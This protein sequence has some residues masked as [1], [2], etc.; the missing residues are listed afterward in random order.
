YNVTLLSE[1]LGE[2]R[3]KVS[4]ALLSL[5]EHQFVTVEQKSKQRTYKVNKETIE[6]LLDLVEKHIK[7]YCKNCR[8][9]DVEEEKT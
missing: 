9:I 7:K 2:E 8:K 6:P 3:S 5:L 1:K 4:H